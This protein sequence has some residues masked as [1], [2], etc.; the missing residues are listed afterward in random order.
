[1]S[2]S[3]TKTRLKPSN[4]NNTRKKTLHLRTNA[5]LNII[6]KI[7]GLNKN[8]VAIQEDPPTKNQSP[9][10]TTLNNTRSKTNSKPPPPP[11]PSF[12]MGG[13]TKRNKTI[14]RK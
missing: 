9:K 5:I 2:K 8:K 14:K 3:Y 6:E 4:N 1:M 7:L 10:T 13:S 11:P 12:F